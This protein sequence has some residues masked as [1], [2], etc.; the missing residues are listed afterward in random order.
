[1]LFFRF[2]AAICKV[3]ESAIVFRSLNVEEAIIQI[4]KLCKDIEH[5][6]RYISLLNIIQNSS[7]SDPETALLFI[8]T[9]ETKE[10]LIQEIVYEINV[11]NII[12]LC[13]IINNYLVLCANI[14]KK[15]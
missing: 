12:S 11:I 5:S 10:S 7:R 1:M 2:I 4:F 3:K 14:Q 13:C 9:K 15:Q 6:N 8:K